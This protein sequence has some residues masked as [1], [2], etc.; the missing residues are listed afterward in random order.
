MESV[1]RP[2]SG[3]FQNGGSVHYAL[4]H[5]QREYIWEQDQWKELLRD[6]FF[7]YQE[8][9]QERSIV[10]FL[11]LMGVVPDEMSGTITKF[12]VVDGQQRLVT[13]S[14][15]LCVLKELS[16][17]KNKNSTIAQQINMVL[18]NPFESGNTR[19]KVLPSTRRGDYATYTSLI[20]GHPLIGRGSRIAD[21]YRYFHREISRR[22]SRKEMSIEK[23][24]EA[25]MNHV[26]VVLVILNRDDEVESPYKIFESL[27]GKGKLLSQADLV[28]NYIAM[29]LPLGFQ[30]QVF[31]EDWVKIESLLNEQNRLGKTGELTAF[32]RHY[33]AMRRQILYPEDRVYARLRDYFEQQVVHLFVAPIPTGWQQHADH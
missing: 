4:P 17:K 19:F 33:L 18:V 15:I 31:E 29:T 23:L 26:Q 30:K 13:V 24:Y 3:I 27:D 8:H 2:I 28:R 16:T 5:F 22:I 14:L 20:D 11:G 6:L 1:I 21:A 12:K 25:L 10:H 9:Q 7:L 32:L